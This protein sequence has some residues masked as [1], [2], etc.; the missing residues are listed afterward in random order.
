M[1]KM[2]TKQEHDDAE[3]RVQAELQVEAFVQL[4]TSRYNLKSED[5]PQILDDMRWLR[6]RRSGIIRIQWAV[7]LGIFAIAISGVMT[8]FWEGVKHAVRGN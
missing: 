5:I 1:Y 6:E 8:A 4:L 2:A 7:A 3:R